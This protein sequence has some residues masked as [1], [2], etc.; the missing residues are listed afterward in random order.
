MGGQGIIFKDTTVYDAGIYGFVQQILFDKL[1]L[2]AGLRLQDHQVY[3]TTWIPAGGLAYKITTHTTLKASISKGFRSP[4]IQELYIWNHNENLSPA[5]IMSYEAGLMQYFFNQKLNLELTGYII[6]GSNMIINVPM[7]GL[8]NV[9]VVNNKGIEVAA[10]ARLVKNMSFN[11]TYSFINMESPVY[12]TPKHHL[13]LSYNYLLRKFQFSS[14][15]QYV[16]SLDTDPTAKVSYQNYAL[17]NSKISY[18]PWKSGELFIS[19]ENILNQKYENNLYYPMPGF[20]LFGGL[21]IRL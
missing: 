7:V 9:G 20:T 18:K 5:T 2:N 16:N 3:G 1:T 12:A 15:L 17:F 11:L 14:S 13:F 4:T 10:T 19:A 6:N 8:Q 21:K